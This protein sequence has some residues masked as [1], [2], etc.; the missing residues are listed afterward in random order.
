MFTKTANADACKKMK[1]DSLISKY[2]NDTFSAEENKKFDKLLKTDEDFKAEFEFEK[3]VKASVISI[4]KDQ[5]KKTLENAENRKPGKN[6]L[7]YFWAASIVFAMGLFSFFMWNN[8][9]VDHA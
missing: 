4:K 6:R 7:T 3:D 2:F 8:A 5:L 1:K 9:P